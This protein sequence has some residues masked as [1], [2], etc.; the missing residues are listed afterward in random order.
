MLIYFYL[1]KNVFILLLFM[2]AIFV[3]FIILGWHLFS[4]SSLGVLF[5]C[6]ATYIVVEKSALSLNII[7]LKTVSFTVY[8]VEYMHL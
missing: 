3:G 4:L 2:K 8:L 6:L 1:S 7:L 5:Y